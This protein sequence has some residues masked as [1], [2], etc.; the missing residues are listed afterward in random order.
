MVTTSPGQFGSGL[1]PSSTLMP[2]Q[3]AGLLDDVDQ[4]GAVLALL[5]DRLVVQDDAGDVLHALGR[6]EQHLAVVAPVVLG[7]FG[8][9]GVEPLLDGAGRFVGGEDALA[10]RGHRHGDFVE[11]CEIHS[12]SP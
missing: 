1:T 12:R 4:R 8:V 6:A 3:R 9:D 2:G 11:F 10:V 7:A 5:P